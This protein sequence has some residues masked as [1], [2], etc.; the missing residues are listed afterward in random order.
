M[1]KI[2]LSTHQVTS[3][4]SVT[5]AINF[6]KIHFGKLSVVVNSAGIVRLGPIYDFVNDKPESL[7]DFRKLLQ[8]NTLGT[9]NVMTR[10]IG[11]MKD[12]VP[13]EDGQRGVIINIGSVAGFDG[14]AKYVA[15]GASKAAVMAM[16]ETTARHVA[17][18][19]IRVVAVAPGF[20]ET[21]IHGNYF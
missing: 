15:Y 9:F 5:D 1:L 6:T 21:P 19:G 10:S 16:T 18:V 4:D 7:D 12:N 11:L 17:S 20:I 3:E 13:D 8:V 14:G 2:I